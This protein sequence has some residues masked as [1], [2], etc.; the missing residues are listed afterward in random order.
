[1]FID[2]FETP[3]VE[4]A[5]L[6][7]AP[8]GSLNH[9][10]SLLPV[11]IKGWLEDLMIELPLFAG[12]DRSHTVIVVPFERY[13]DQDDE[14]LPKRRHRGHWRCIVVDSDHPSYPVGGHRLSIPESQLVRGTL[15]TFELASPVST[16]GSDL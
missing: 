9:S 3:E 12:P 7:E 11:N 1:V 15:R 14:P 2:L 8:V 5:R 4:V 6:A 10:L 16:A 13:K